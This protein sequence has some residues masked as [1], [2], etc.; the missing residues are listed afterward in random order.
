[1]LISQNQSAKRMNFMT[2]AIFAWVAFT[3]FVLFATN[4]AKAADKP[5]LPCE[6]IGIATGP[7][8]KGF[9]KFFKDINAVCGAKIQLCEVNSE[10]GLDNLTLLATNKADI[11]FTMADAWLRMGE[12][13]AKIKSFKLVMNT[14]LSYLH[15]LVRTGGHQVVAGKKWGLVEDKQIVYIKK[16]SELKG[17]PVAMVGS[18]QLMGRRLDELYNMNFRIIDVNGPTADEDAFNML[19]RGE[20]F[21]VMTISGAPNGKVEKLKAEDGLRLADFDFKAENPYKVGKMS[22]RNL[23]QYGTD[24]LTIQNAIVTRPFGGTKAKDVANIKACI[25]ANLQDL[26]DGRGEPGWSEVEKQ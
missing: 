16:F 15:I 19:K 13:D 9:S 1:M 22:Y 21:A 2:L 8:G 11:G 25:L 6:G 24:A 14:N 10:G 12:A 26:K 20:V 7:A 5:Q 3:I 17:R 4:N 23:G 18:T